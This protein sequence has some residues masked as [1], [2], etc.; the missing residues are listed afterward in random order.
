MSE[1]DASVALPFFLV[2]GILTVLAVFDWIRNLDR[3]RGNRWVW[4]AVIL[5]LT[6]I[7]PIIYFIFG[8]RR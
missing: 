6:I 4:L 8:K 3:I 5:V 1:L 2:Q 7:G